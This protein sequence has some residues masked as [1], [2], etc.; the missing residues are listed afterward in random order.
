[1]P[2]PE[3]IR[4]MIVDD[5]AET[6]E[7]IRRSLQFDQIIEVIGTARN[8]KE[9]LQL[10]EELKPDVV[11]MDIN[12]P[13]MD[14]ITATEEIRKKVPYAQIVILSVQSDPSYMRRAMLVGARDFL[15]KPPSIDELTSAIRRAGQVAIEER[16]KSAKVVETQIANIQQSVSGASTNAGKV[17]IVYSPKGGTGC[18]TVATNLALALRPGDKKVL[19]VDGSI[20]FGDVAV[21]LNE[22]A[23]NSVADLT[24]RVD[25]LDTEVVN[26]VLGTHPASG[27]RYL[28]SPQH[29]EAAEKVNGEQFGKLLA[30][31]RKM[32]DYIVVDTN[33]YLSD[34]IQAALTEADIITLITTQD[35]PAIKS[36]SM[37][38]GLA[39]SSG[40]DRKQILFV[41]NKF[42]KRIAITPEKVGVNLRQEI[43]VTIPLDDKLIL[44]SSV[45][46]GIPLLLDN[47]GHPISK[48]IMSIADK[49][50]EQ[51]ENIDSPKPVS[52]K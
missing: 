12:M 43:I 7:N 22:Q 47:K 6:R 48:S 5:I 17:I 8:G 19:L 34:N 45:N 36:C 38:L 11:I 41:M 27:L 18:T 15:T 37:F 2:D 35:I 20:Q 46:R 52:K 42:D 4:V 44:T 16:S 26:G 39:D 1:M 9:A 29:L 30:F 33:S 31:L 24:P 21:F 23:R 10:S 14:G 28:A 3:K 40:I 51:I 25:E 50:K 32:F 49:L 13:D